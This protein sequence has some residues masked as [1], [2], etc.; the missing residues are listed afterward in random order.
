MIDWISRWPLVVYRLHLGWTM[1]HRFMLV[2]HR[3]RKSGKVY[4][5]GVMVLRFD[6]P[7]REAFVVAGSKNADWYLNIQSSPALVINLGRQEY[8]P[9]QRLLTCDEIAEL[10]ALSRRHAPF[11]A[12]MQAL[13][14]GWPL[15]A[16]RKEL[17][18]L[19]A[20]LGG[21]AFRPA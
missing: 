5:T 18:A 20:T 9:V 10:L 1:G 7:S 16:D 12:L 19:A 11:Q 14:F 2:T 17:L 21:V 4:Y 8:R 6:K 13:F 3:G 15:R